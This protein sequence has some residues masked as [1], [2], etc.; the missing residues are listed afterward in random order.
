MTTKPR[1][2]TKRSPSKSARRIGG[3]A[4]ALLL[5]QLLQEGYEARR[6]H[7]SAFP[8]I[9]AWNE[10]GLLLIEV[11][12]RADKPAYI[13][14][15]KSIFKASADTLIKLPEFARVLCYLRVNKAWKVFEYRDSVIFVQE[16]VL[17]K[18]D[19]QS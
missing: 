6:T 2:T 11:K 9:L 18:D 1:K 5:R 7:L 4:E 10:H 19:P 8:D 12:A 15:A 16:S 3:S 17:S 13:N 14:Q